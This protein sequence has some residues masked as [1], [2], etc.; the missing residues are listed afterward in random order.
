MSDKSI[1]SK[2]ERENQKTIEQEK[3]DKRNVE[4]NA[5]NSVGNLA[6]LSAMSDTVGEEQ[7]DL[8][9]RT[10]PAEQRK[11]IVAENIAS[12]KR[13]VE[14]KVKYSKMLTE[15]KE[16]KGAALRQRICRANRSIE[17]NNE[18]KD[19]AAKDRKNARSQLLST[20]RISFQQT[21]SSHMSDV[22]AQLYNDFYEKSTDIDGAHDPAAG[23][24]LD[25]FVFKNTAE[26]LSFNNLVNGICVVCDLQCAQ[27]DLTYSKISKMFIKVLLI[28]ILHA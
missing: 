9:W 26:H 8:N 2:A 15:N 13:K 14:E 17:K 4:Q 21:G 7:R 5:R 3:K 6:K 19:K 22:E 1:K 11:A 10:M 18:I 27:S 23:K 28:N 20:S 24:P 16:V 12:Q 25:S